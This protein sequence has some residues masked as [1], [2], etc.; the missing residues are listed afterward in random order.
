MK[1]HSCVP[2]TLHS[3]KQAVGC[4]LS[5]LDLREEETERGK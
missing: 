4:G 1:E 3:E 5:T 2:V